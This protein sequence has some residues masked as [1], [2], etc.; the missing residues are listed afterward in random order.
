MD[1]LRVIFCL[2]RVFLFY[3]GVVAQCRKTLLINRC[4]HADDLGNLS[5]YSLQILFDIGDFL[6]VTVSDCKLHFEC[7]T[8]LLSLH[9]LAGQ[10]CLG[11]DAELTTDSY[12]ILMIL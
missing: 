10:K 4:C 9:I 6:Y 7:W 8:W 1:V 12:S 3:S 5:L 11:G 2:F